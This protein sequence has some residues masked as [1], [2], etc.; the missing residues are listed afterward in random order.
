MEWPVVDSV[1]VVWVELVEWRFRRWI[2]PVAWQPGNRPD[3]SFLDPVSIERNY[4][5]T[6]H[7]DWPF[8]MRSLFSLLF[9]LQTVH[10]P[11]T[12]PTCECVEVLP[13]IPCHSIPDLL[14]RTMVDR[15]LILSHHGISKEWNKNLAR[16]K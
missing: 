13:M 12:L 3:R 14:P 4:C 6:L 15:T 9:Y 8:L 5:L 11:T 10:L 2:S 1:E 7:Y 16:I